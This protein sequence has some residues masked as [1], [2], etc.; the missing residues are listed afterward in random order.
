M[1]AK[2]VELAITKYLVHEANLEDLDLLNE[3]IQHPDNELLFENYVRVHYKA[4]LAVADCDVNEIKTVLLDRIKNENRN[5][6][7]LKTRRSIIKYAAAV[8]VGVSSLVYFFRDDIV[9]E[10]SF[11][12]N[13]VIINNNITPGESK[14][15]LTLENGEEIFFVKGTSL[16]TKNATANGEEIVYEDAAD[17]EE[18]VYNTLTIPRG[19]QFFV[20]LSD[21]T[22][23]W[24]NSETKL[25]Y[26][27]HF[28][29]GKS[30]QVELLYG[31]AFFEVSPSELNSGSDFRVISYAQEIQVLGTKFNVKSYPEDKNIYTTLQEG[32]VSINL[33][34]EKRLL[35][36]NQQAVVNIESQ[37]IEIKPADIR[38][39]TAWLNGEFILK[40]KT[41][42]AIM[43]ELSRWYDMDVVFEN[44][45]LEDVKFVGVLGKDQSIVEI[46][47]TIQ[48]F[49]I[50]N[51][52][53]I[54]NKNVV[55]K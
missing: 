27:V 35:K 10:S 7:R 2:K 5:V 13:T 33:P 28:I 23:V 40:H 4:T 3:W 46:L 48:G 11:E 25:K 26:P 22:K 20:T 45:N 14:A 30:R 49:G 36:P 47:N 39:E 50:I 32:E 24:L 43:Q 15:K 52:Y 55:I 12:N 41:L 1:N 6:L 53:E 31:E 51:G 19:G 16:K 17:S 8:L 9:K 34:N 18:I 37:N 54:N 21:G 29:K 44:K 42:K 38:T